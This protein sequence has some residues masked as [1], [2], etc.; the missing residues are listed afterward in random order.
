[1]CTQDGWSPTP[2]GASWPR[3]H[4]SYI[5]IPRWDFKIQC[6]ILYLALLFV[7][8][9]RKLIEISHRNLSIQITIIKQGYIP[10]PVSAH[11]FTLEVRSIL[12]CELPAAQ[13]FKN[14]NWNKWKKSSSFSTRWICF[15]FTPS[16]CFL[17]LFDISELLGPNLS[18]T[19]LDYFVE[20]TTTKPKN[21]YLV[22]GWV[23]LVSEI[24]LA[25][26]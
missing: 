13:I 17:F 4:S 21:N 23:L 25:D 3:G 15:K 14:T 18:K 5:N 9:R 12:R 2:H 20:N 22:E 8:L 19:N 10:I 11:L 1:M 16:F 7:F 24:I 6:Q 26:H